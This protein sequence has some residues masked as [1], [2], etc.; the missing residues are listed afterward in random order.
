M[1][2]GSDGCG[3]VVEVGEKVDKKWLNKIVVINPAEGWGDIEEVLFAHVLMG[4]V[5]YQR[6]ARILT[7][8]LV[9]FKHRRSI[10]WE[11]LETGLSHLMSSSQLIKSRKNHPI[12]IPRHLVDHLQSVLVVGSKDVSALR[13]IHDTEFFV[14]G[15]GMSWCGFHDG[16]SRSVYQ[17][18]AQEERNGLTSLP[19]YLDLIP[20]SRSI[21][22]NNKSIWAW[23]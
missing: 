8:S 17:G 10:C 2:L 13:P 1:T 23:N 14:I 5:G 22:L 18:T 7:I 11:C 21:I 6:C 20:H 12:S 15:G 16:L 19:F 4:M 3:V 9:R